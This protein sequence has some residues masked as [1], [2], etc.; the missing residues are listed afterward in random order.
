MNNTSHLVKNEDLN[1]HGTLYAGRMADWFIEACFIEA[2]LHFSNPENIV[3]LKIH[4][5]KFS[6]PA[7]KGNIVHIRTMFAYTGKTSIMIYGKA[8][9]GSNPC[10]VMVDGFVTFVSVDKK[11]NKMPHNIVFTPK[12]DE[13]NIIHKKAI[14]LRKSELKLKQM[15]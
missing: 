6:A 5:L 8:F 3:C 2:N 13:E 12:S 15:L 9:K 4:G 14:R 1:H 10:N 7:K 11:G